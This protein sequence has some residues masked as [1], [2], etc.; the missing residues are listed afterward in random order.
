MKV[1]LRITGFDEFAGRGDTRG[2]GEDDST[3]KSLTS[4][5]DIGVNVVSYHAIYLSLKGP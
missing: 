3:P 5:G 4:R 1:F 2:D